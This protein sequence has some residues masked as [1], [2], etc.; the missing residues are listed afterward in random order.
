VLVYTKPEAN[1]VS[2]GLD[3]AIRPYRSADPVTTAAEFVDANGDPMETDSDGSQSGDSTN[4]A[5]KGAPDTGNNSNSLFVP[6]ENE[7][8]QTSES[9]N[10]AASGANE[11]WPWNTGLTHDGK[12][13]MAY[14]THGRGHRAIVEPKTG[15]EVFDV[16]SGME[17]GGSEMQ[18]YLAQEGILQLK[19]PATRRK[20]SY[21]HR[22][23]FVKLW[24]LAT[25][26]YKT[27]NA[28]SKSGSRRKDPEAWGFAQWTWGFEE[29]VVS[30][31]RKV[32]GRE[33]A[34]A[35]IRAICKKNNRTPPMEQP[36]QQILVKT[37]PEMLAGNR[38]KETQLDTSLGGDLPYV[39]GSSNPVVFDAAPPEQR[40]TTRNEQV[41]PKAGF[42]LQSVLSEMNKKLELLEKK[43]EP[44]DE[45]IK[46]TTVLTQIVTKLAERVGLNTEG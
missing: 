35:A 45:L 5:E 12:R 28:D 23:D 8:M 36:P 9:T 3:D 15:S 37:T 24:Y 7:P 11:T 29:I 39:C 44:V 13:I 16:R 25:S 6:E 27:H 14:R 38:L 10:G 17:C 31:L 42:D 40:P 46:N 19:P 32:V 21:E 34:D 43:V 18:R 22:G 20:W 30:D 41:E 4:P 1:F 26:D 2:T 33:S